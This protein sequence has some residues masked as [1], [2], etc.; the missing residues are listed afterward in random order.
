MSDISAEVMGQL[1]DLANRLAWKAP[2]LEVLLPEY[3][4]KYSPLALTLQKHIQRSH[5]RGK[6]ILP[7]LRAFGNQSVGLFSDYSGESK[8]NYHIYSVLVAGWNLV[9]PFHQRM[10]TIRDDHSLG[11][12][13]IEFKD[14]RMGQIQRALPEYLQAL[15]NLVPGFL[16]TLAVDKQLMTLFGPQE[17]ETHKRLAELLRIEELG[18]RKPHVAE[19]SPGRPL[20]GVFV[21][22]FGT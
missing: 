20:D 8:G 14:F 1:I 16:F 19:N 21:R 13:E 6:L 12:K 4:G 9:G 18:E 17:A 2:Y 3:E 7:D 10:L 22:A 15:D 5:I 11:S